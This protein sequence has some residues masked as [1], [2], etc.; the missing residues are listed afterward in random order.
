MVWTQTLRCRACCAEL[1]ALSLGPLRRP[2]IKRRASSFN[3]PRLDPIIALH[4]CSI[5]LKIHYG[6]LC[7]ANAITHIVKETQPDEIYNLA[8]QSHVAVSFKM[9]MYTADVNATGTLILLEAVR[10][11]GLQHKTRFYQVRRAICFAFVN[12]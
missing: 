9:P 2:G 10:L 5:N 1:T 12:K 3:Q 4:P 6:D 11:C 7:D 8:A